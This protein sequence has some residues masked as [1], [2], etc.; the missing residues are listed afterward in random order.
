MA[1]SAGRPAWVLPSTLPCGVRTFLELI[2]RGRP[3]DSSAPSIGAR[4]IGRSM[5]Q[6]ALLLV[7]LGL[8][9]CAPEP[10]GP[11][12][13]IAR[14]QLVAGTALEASGARDAAVAFVQAYADSGRVGVGPLARLVAGADLQTWVRWL[15][16]QHREFPGMIQATTDL[17]DIV[18][19]ETVEAGRA[20]GAQVSVSA[21]VTFA[22]DPTD[23]ERFQRNRIL[24]GPMTLVRTS[25]GGYLVVDLLRD[26]VP[27]SDGIHRFQDETRTERDLTVTLDS[28]FTF[29]PNWQFN[30]IVENGGDRDVVLD[31]DGAALAVRRGGGFERLEGAMTGSLAV[32]PAGTAVDGILAYPAQEDAAGRVLSLV[33]LEGRRARR[34]E[35]PLEDL[36]TV[37]PPPPPAGEVPS[38]EI[39]A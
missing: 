27:M 13:P 30:V 17:R 2:A 8:V 9:A 1:L 39:E 5:R 4:I 26:G 18:F 24:D 20:N 28:L 21:S 36:V 33:Y 16:V 23:G 29:P 6:P 31:P 35:F 25:P 11:V 19:V 32:I 10:Q 22:F 15:G 34:F 3:A 12:A 14:E 37:V 38:T 7:A